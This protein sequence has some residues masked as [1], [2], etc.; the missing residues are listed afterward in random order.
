LH[1]TGTID[2]DWLNVLM[3]AIK[4]FLVEDH[5]PI[6]EKI[7]EL[8]L[9]VAGAEV[10]GTADD[11]AEAVI[12]ISSSMPDVVVV[13]LNLKSGT[14]GLAVLEWLVEH[15]PGVVAVVLSNLV[16]PQIKQLCLD[17]GARLV[18]DKAS[19]A[20]L[21]RDAVCEIART[22]GGQAPASA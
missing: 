2:P 4:V 18:L 17:L 10:V 3:R 6:R 20:F 14:S 15:A 11:L 7:A 21:L 22:R 13:D 1:D 16:Y 8:I 9:T 19:E 12:G 5:A